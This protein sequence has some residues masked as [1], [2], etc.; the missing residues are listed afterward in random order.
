MSDANLHF[1]DLRFGNS[2]KE[3]IACKTDGKTVCAK[4]A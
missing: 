4:A 3:N 2:T 1:H